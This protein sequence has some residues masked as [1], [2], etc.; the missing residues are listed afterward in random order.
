[1]QLPS[2]VT[3]ELGGLPIIGNNHRTALPMGH[4]KLVTV[5]KTSETTAIVIYTRVAGSRAEQGVRYVT[6]QANTV[7]NPGGL[8]VLSWSVN[9]GWFTA[10]AGADQEVSRKGTISEP[11]PVLQAF[12]ARA[13]RD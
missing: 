5:R 10:I 13:G 7:D 3:E 12:W 8:T 1:M 6:L 9:G 11:L 4:E 2:Q